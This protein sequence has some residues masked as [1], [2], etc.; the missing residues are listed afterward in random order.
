MRLLLVEDDAA[1][2]S[3]LSHALQAEGYAVDVAD[4]GIDGAHLGEV[5]PYDAVILDLGLSGRPGLDALTAWRA[6]GNAVPVVILTAR[7]SWQEKV[8]GLKA[9]ADDSLA[10]PFQ[11]AELLARLQAVV[12]RHKGHASAQLEAGGI[13]LDEAQQQARVGD[14]PV[15]ELTG[16]EFRLLRVFM[17]HPDRPLSRTWLYEHVYG[18]AEERDSN[19]IEVYVRPLRDKL[20]AAIIETR[21][22]Q[23]YLFR[24]LAG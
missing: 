12:R 3:G 24:G 21:R 8:A 10:K 1:L 15:I 14:G 19:V 13:Q 22:G 16:T 23:G 7:D 4:N 6:A 2:A 18:Y 20:G 17:L 9:G 5:E 11:F